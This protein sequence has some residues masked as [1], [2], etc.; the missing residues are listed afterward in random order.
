MSEALTVS[1]VPP[2]VQPLPD[3]GALMEL[4][5]VG[6]VVSICT[7]WLIWLPVS[8]AVIRCVPSPSTVMEPWPVTGS[9]LTVFDEPPSTW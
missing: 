8:D 7:T 5:I 1:V 9:R 2:L 4:L 6:G 3:C